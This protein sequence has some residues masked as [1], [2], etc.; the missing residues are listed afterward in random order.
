MGNGPGAFDQYEALVRRY[1]RL[2]GGFVW[3]WRDHGLLA[4]AADG[5]PY[6]AYGGDFG[7]VVH[8]GNFVMDGMLLSNDVPS[9]SLFE[10]AAVTRPIDF[11]FEGGKVAVTNLRHT[12]DSADLGFRWR[13]E[14]DGV[15]VASGE[16][17][18]PVLA[19][20]ESGWA[21]VPPVPV[22]SDAETW[23][24]IEAALTRPTPWAPAGHVV[25][26]AQLDC[27][28]RRVVPAV[29]SRDD[30]RPGYGNLSVG[31]AEF[32]GGSLVRLADRPV[33]GPRLEL[34]RAPTDNDESPS[35]G[36]EEAM[37]ASPVRRTPTCGVATASTV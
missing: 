24:T 22:A 28:E 14:H 25:A 13:V 18:V 20:G 1:P 27:T 32:S 2:H 34:F 30:W 11:V 23:L 17:A 26:T 15:P 12:A 8:D 29:R 33:T 21:P 35:D 5:T 9:P 10:F 37:T 6:Y 4:T 36:V 7:E 31:I 16:L 3:E 19:A